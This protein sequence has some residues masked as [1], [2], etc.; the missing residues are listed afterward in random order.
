MNDR[1]WRQDAACRGQDPENWVPPLDDEGTVGPVSD[2]A[3]TLC[4]TCPVSVQCLT[5]VLTEPSTIG[6][7]AGTDKRDR[8]LLRSTQTDHAFQAGCD[9]R[10]CTIFADYVWPIG[11]RAL[12]NSNG[13]G[14]QCGLTSTFGRGCRCTACGHANKSAWRK[15]QKQAKQ[16]HQVQALPAPITQTRH[17]QH[18]TAL[19]AIRP[20]TQQELFQ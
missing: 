4:A 6:L 13:L 20:P 1:S 16:D 7:W 2:L 14:A 18:Q 19:A 3:K 12:L 15:Q 10:F 11:E 17:Q 9:C 8:R 5:F